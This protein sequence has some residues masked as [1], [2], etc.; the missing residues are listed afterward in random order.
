MFI[1]MKIIQGQL[2]HPIILSSKCGPYSSLKFSEYNP[3]VTVYT[4][5]NVYYIYVRDV[6]SLLKI[7]IVSVSF[8][9]IFYCKAAMDF[10]D[11][12]MKTITAS[13]I[14]LTYT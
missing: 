3:F 14:H 4:K 8:D 5:R 1:L 12:N 13:V 6:N 11:E 7:S 9:Q 10:K 2:Q